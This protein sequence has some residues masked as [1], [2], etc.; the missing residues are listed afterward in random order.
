MSNQPHSASQ[1]Q[2]QS[3]A[4]ISSTAVSQPQQTTDIRLAQTF[5]NDFPIGAAVSAQTIH[6]QRDLLL[7]QY[8]SLT[9]ENEMK[10]ISVHPHEHQYTFEQADKIANFARQHELELRGHTFV[11]HNQTPDWVFH[12]EQ[13]GKADRATLLARLH[14]HM[15]TVMGRYG[16]VI[17]C[18]DVVN[19]AISDEDGTYLR[20]TPWLEGVGEDYIARAFEMAHA[21]DPQA[22]LFY[23]DY[24]ES[25]PGKC[26]RICR[27]MRELLDQGVPVHGI[28]LQAHWNIYDPSLDWIRA[29]IERY[30][31]LGLQLQITEMDVSMFA[32][33]DRRTDL[34]VPTAEMLRLQ[35]QRYR[36]YFRLFHEYRD[37]LTS[38][39]FWGAADDY[40]WL[41]GFPVRGRKNWPLLFDEQQ[42]P[43]PVCYEIVRERQSMEN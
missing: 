24:N 21:I 40:T 31:A 19:E 6:S 8:S 13:G 43:K 22:L 27:L 32:F 37:V 2:R 10:F 26:E 38:V 41:D 30:A 15:E 5:R 3:A 11:W 29:A 7:Q 9:A 1:A 39:T 25:H 18:W 28:G 14:Q 17:R 4:S 16:D 20:P 23:N 33:E 34:K 35:E 42:Q 12:N 36:D